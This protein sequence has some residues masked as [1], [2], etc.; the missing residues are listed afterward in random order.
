MECE[1]AGGCQS[2]DLIGDSCGFGG[3]KFR[4]VQATIFMRFGKGQLDIRGKKD[5]WM[6]YFDALRE[7]PRCI[8]DLK[9]PYVTFRTS[10]V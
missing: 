10:V 1:V 2:N 6:G 4:H 8:Y 7:Y 9:F 3:P 5:C